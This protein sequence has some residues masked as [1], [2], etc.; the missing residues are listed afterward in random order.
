MDKSGS[1]LVTRAL[2]AE[3]GFTDIE[4]HQP[5]P[6]KGVWYPNR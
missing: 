2:A 4:G 5:S 1:I 6:E 3:Y